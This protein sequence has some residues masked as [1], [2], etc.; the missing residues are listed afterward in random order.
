M[1]SWKVETR[2]HRERAQPR[3]RARLGLLEK[4]A[5]YKKRADAHHSK[6]ARLRS[7]K[8]KAEMRNPDEFYFGMVKSQTSVSTPP[9]S[10]RTKQEHAPSRFASGWRAQAV[11]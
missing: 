9:I 7:M 5:D 8:L 4:H 3:G 11:C 10:A 1:S 2:A 6:A